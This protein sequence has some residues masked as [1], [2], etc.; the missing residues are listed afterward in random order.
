MSSSMDRY[1][2]GFIDDS[3]I[4]DWHAVLYRG[5]V[6]I[7]ILGSTAFAITDTVAGIW[8]DKAFLFVAAANVALATMTIDY[9]ARL[10]A[11]M[12]GC[13]EE[14][15][16]GLGRYCCSAYGIFD[17]L[18]VAPF[19]FSFAVPVSHDVITIFSILGFLKLARYSPALGTLGTVVLNELRPLSAALFI[20]T[21]LAIASATVLYF[22]ERHV[23]ENLA[24]VPAALWWSIVTLTTVG[25]GDVVPTTPLGKML[26]SVV[27][28]LGL[29]MFALPASILA[30]GFADE[31]RRNDL[32][33]KLKLISKVPFISKLQADQI[34][35][36]SAHLKP[37]RASKG[38]I[39]MKAGDIG[40]CMYFIIGGQVDVTIPAGSFTLS[41]GEF[42]GEIA[43]L[44]R[45]P[46]TATIK[47]LV[48]SQFL[49]LE[50]LDFQKAIAS[51]PEVLAAI[52]EQAG[53][54][55]G[56]DTDQ[57]R[58]PDRR[59]SNDRRSKQVR[60]ADDKD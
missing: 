30:S 1:V 26:G 37:Y 8:Q 57:R 24:S 6:I 18:A 3:P 35:E 45:C 5:L 36:L 13:G 14:G 50:A 60:K 47:A 40:D 28:V 27:A 23:N 16:S 54:R 7:C 29:C 38:E 9:L 46:R 25:Y 58:T 39:L 17:I 44:E 2:L 4:A 48:R 59:V 43:L 49:V 51:N 10:R 22:A 15:W 42:F 55:L 33:A 19:L 32:F 31:M 56:R 12:L 53:R 34:T 21:L 52:R 20:I 11:S 41:V